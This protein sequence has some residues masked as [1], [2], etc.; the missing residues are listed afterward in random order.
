MQ[1][2]DFFL[3]KINIRKCSRSK[4]RDEVPVWNCE[5]IRDK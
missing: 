3:L 1:I 2:W 4:K 5:P